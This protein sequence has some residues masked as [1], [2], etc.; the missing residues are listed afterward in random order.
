MPGPA[1]AGDLDQPTTSRS[2]EPAACTA[3]VVKNGCGR[4]AMRMRSARRS[5]GKD[6]AQRVIRVARDWRA[7]S[8]GVFVLAIDGHGGAGKS[9]IADAVARAT[10]AAL[11]RTDDF[12]RRP[13]VPAGRP[14][15]PGGP[16]GR[17]ALDQYYDWRRLRAEAIEPLRAGRDATFRRFDWDRG[18]GLDAGVVVR[19]SA[20][21]L[22]EGVFSAAPQLAD[23]VDR[24]VLVDTPE[25]ERLRRLRARIA[26]ADWDPDWLIAEQAY[27]RQTRPPAWFDLIVPGAG[28]P[29]GDLCGGTS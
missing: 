15:A 2:R 24:S 16:A 12:F 3:P 25:Q 27:F 17:L 6:A 18:T 4:A 26:P 28:R 20:L 1:R 5:R 23:L 7:A 9:T 14:P 19:R 29:A 21:I 11:V 10:G 8:P 22:V 13:P